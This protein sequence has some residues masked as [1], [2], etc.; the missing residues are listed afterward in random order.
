MCLLDGSVERLSADLCPSGNAMLVIDEK[1]TKNG[2]Q[3]SGQ[4]WA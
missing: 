4:R 1:H 3:D 2:E